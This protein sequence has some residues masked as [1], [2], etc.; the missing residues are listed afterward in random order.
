MSSTL[1]VGGGLGGLLLADKLAAA[2]LAV[3]V[4]ERTAAFGGGSRFV[5]HAGRRWPTAIYSSLGF[6]PGSRLAEVA[7]RPLDRFPVSDHVVL[8]GREYPLPGTLAGLEAQL[9]AWFPAERSGLGRFVA[10]VSEVYQAID[11]SLALTEA[12]GRMA[13]LGRLQE[14]GRRT[15]RELRDECVSDPTLRRLL[16]VRAFASTN[17]A[18]TM[19]AYLG[20]I[21]VDGLYPIAGPELAERLVARLGTRPS[22]RLRTS[23]EVTGIAF[24]AEGRGAEAVVTASGE[25]LAADEIVLDC[26]LT[27]LD[28]EFVAD[29]TVR[30]VFAPHLDGFLPGLSGLTLQFAL[31]PAFRPALE[32]LAGAARIYVADGADPLDVLVRREAGEL[33]LATLKINLDRSAPEPLVGVEIDA[34]PGA[35][36]DGVPAAVSERAA[37]V[38]ERLLPGFGAA[39]RAEV[40]FTPQDYAAWSGARGGAASG[41]RDAV[42]RPFLLYRALERRGI[43]SVGQWSLFGSGLSQLELSAQTSFQAIRR[44]ALARRP[45]TS[46]SSP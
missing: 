13:A 21:H 35:V 44:R 18:S 24:D 36:R 8:D 12:P 3:T 33:D 38:L 9:G 17:T 40:T 31:D 42:A 7:G 4:L 1:I 37:G 22:C 20:K 29:P 26:D 39:V 5:E 25:R 15:F 19:L 46:E 2:G 34:T 11:A 23:T 14:Y 16:A 28:S 41:F 6:E 30:R 32:R 43:S 10:A 45:N 27:H